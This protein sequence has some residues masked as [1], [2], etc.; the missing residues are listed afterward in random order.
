MELHLNIGQKI[1]EKSREKVEKDFFKDFIIW[2]WLHIA[3]YLDKLSQFSPNFGTI[4][5]N[6]LLLSD[7]CE[8]LETSRLQVLLLTCKA[9]KSYL[10]TENLHTYWINYNSLS[11]DSFRLSTKSC[12]LFHKG[13]QSNNRF[14]NDWLMYF[15]V[16][17]NCSNQIYK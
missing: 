16:L 7:T 9:T 6:H 5:M 2:L 10:C 8:T 12:K 14:V 1:H 3:P 11:R 15:S 4:N 13:G 17:C